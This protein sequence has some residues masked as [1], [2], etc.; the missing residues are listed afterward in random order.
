MGFVMAEG[1]AQPFQESGEFYPA[2][3]NLVP[4][5]R[6]FALWFLG[7]TDKEISLFGVMVGGHSEDLTPNADLNPANIPDGRLQVYIQDAEPSGE[8]FQ[9]RVSHSTLA[10][11]GARRFQIRDVG[12]GNQAG[13]CVRQLPAEVMGEQLPGPIHFPP[14][15][16]LVGFRLFFI[17]GREREVQR[18]GVWFENDELHIVMRDQSVGLTDT[19][20]YL[21]DFVTIPRVGLNITTGTSESTAVGWDRFQHVTPPRSN[22]LI[23]GWELEFLNGDHE[24]NGIGVDRRP[25]FGNNEFQVLYFDNNAD[26]PFRWRV[27]WAHVGPMVFQGPNPLA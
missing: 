21:V 11:P 12:C 2:F 8:K 18:V 23:T 7:E 27:D 15:L 6:N 17:G 4:A 22:F 5:L 26:D 10:I 13:E 20:G 14:L 16:A 19:F 9:Y 1:E 25:D 24:I 3:G